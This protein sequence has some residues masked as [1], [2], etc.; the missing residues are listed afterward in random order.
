MLTKQ[1]M[2][3]GLGGLLGV[4]T[5][6]MPA[7]AADEHFAPLSGEEVQE[8]VMQWVD[9]QGNVEPA[10]QQE[11]AALWE[12]VDVSPSVALDKAVASFGLVDPVTQNFINDCQLVG[13]P[14]VAPEFI[15]EAEGK[16]G[17]FGNTLRLYYA[18]YLSQR[19]M[20]D[21][22]L[23]Q[24]SQLDPARV[25]DPATCLFYQAVCQH[26]LLMK[27][28]GL[29]SIERLL[30]HTEDVP[31][32][33]TSVAKLMQFELEQLREDTLDEV[34][35]MM[36]DVERR[37][38]LGRAGRKVQKREA[39]IIAALDY[40]I[41]KLE[42]QSCSGSCA[43][44]GMGGNKNQS[45]S[46]AKDS[47]VKGNTA[48]GDADRKQIAQNSGWGMLPEKEQADAKQYMDKN[49]PPHYRKVMEEYFKRIAER[50]QR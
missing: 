47:S 18:R 24:F 29:K 10:V 38:D 31:V 13:G 16:D 30:S 28:E 33:Y 15:A 44:S 1:T 3:W 39:E 49:F 41:E 50:K 26:E 36:N 43:C 21:E 27:D 17:F 32:R 40:L 42:Q 46:P 37:L 35:R 4:L 11:L 20:Y 14:L 22:A 5:I 25:I 45:S 9:A 7:A 48:P 34:A 2:V 6:A 8:A 12:D 19:R 23:V